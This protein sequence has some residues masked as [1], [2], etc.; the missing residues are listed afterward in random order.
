MDVLP[1]VGLQQPV[2]FSEYLK[3][4]C[5]YHSLLCCWW[6]IEFGCIIF[7]QTSSVSSSEKS[8]FVVLARDSIKGWRFIAS[9]VPAAGLGLDSLIIYT[10]SLQSAAGRVSVC[11]AAFAS[12]FGT[13]G[14]S[15]NEHE[16][17]FNIRI[18]NTPAKHG[19]WI[20]RYLDIHLSITFLST[21]Q[22]RNIFGLSWAALGGSSS[23]SGMMDGP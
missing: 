16:Q 6:R 5:I 7:M 9:I 13:I 21:T 11:E 4:L 14:S 20:N 22:Q 18:Q 10:S 15:F 3:S 17:F 19:S 2:H 1:N 12:I 8:T 23:V